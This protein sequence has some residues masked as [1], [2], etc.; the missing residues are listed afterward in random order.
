MMMITMLS[1]MVNDD[2][3]VENDDEAKSPSQS[4]SKRESNTNGDKKNYF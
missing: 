2:G 4:K 3:D 1:L